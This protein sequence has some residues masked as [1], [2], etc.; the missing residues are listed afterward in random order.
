MILDRNM[1]K[2]PGGKL[3]FAA[4]QLLLRRC[5]PWRAGDQSLEHL[6]FRFSKPQVGGELQLK[7]GL[8]HLGSGERL[9]I[10]SSPGVAGRLLSV[11]DENTAPIVEC[12]RIQHESGSPGS[13]SSPERR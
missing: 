11:A 1:F 10:S 4:L 9:L 8:Y 3:V 7:I 13:Q 5:D 12:L 2:K 6:R